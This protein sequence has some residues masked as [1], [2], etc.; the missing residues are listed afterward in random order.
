[1]KII[2]TITVCLLAVMAAKCSSAQ[3]VYD[4]KSLVDSNNTNTVNSTSTVNSTNTNTNTNVNTNNNINS[5]TQTINNNNNLL[6]VTLCSSCLVYPSPSRQGG[7]RPAV[8]EAAALPAQT[9]RTGRRGPAAQ[10]IHH[11]PQAI[12][13]VRSHV[14]TGYVSSHSRDRPAG[15]RTV[16]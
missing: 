4:T 10:Q 14:F 1:M 8:P 9:L 11:L 12:L 2:A 5:G 3:T 7:L 13:C 15:G 6:V 16:L